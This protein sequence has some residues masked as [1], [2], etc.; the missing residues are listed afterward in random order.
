MNPNLAR[1]NPYPFDRLN[2]LLQTVTPADQ[3]FISLAMGEPQHE[4]P[5]FLIDFLKQGDMAKQSLKTYPPTKGTDELRQAIAGFLRRRFAPAHP[6]PDHQIL[7]VNGTREAL[8]A[9]A[10]A[11]SRPQA[12]PLTLLPNPFYQIYEGAALLAGTTPQ[13][14][15]CP[16]SNDFKPN[17]DDIDADT[18]QRVGMVY[19]CNPGNPH[20]GLMTEQDLQT[21]IRTA[22]E[23][24]VILIADECYSEIYADEAAPPVGL[25]QAAAAMGNTDFKQCLAFNSLSKRSNLPGLRSGYVAG[26]ADLIRQFLLYRT[27]HGSAMPVHAQK[28]STLAWSDERHVIE[29][30]ALYR[31][32]TKAFVQ[33][34]APVWPITPPAASFYLWPETPIDDEQF[35]QNLMQS[36]NIKVLP[37]QY[38]SRTVDGVN[39]GVGRVRIALVAEQS[40][41]IEAAERI[42]VC[43]QDLG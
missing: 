39:P 13:Y 1:L 4:P 9:V 20:G 14:L 36:C 43:F 19:L 37:G 40:D 5:E 15:S 38:L 8:F 6:D 28:L 25:L 18:W 35:T 34:L 30:R 27:Y 17:F 24:D 3:R 2:Q 10:Q 11:L 22:I 32:K 26:N 21:L 16:A 33:T 29:N 7:P 41:C 23:H 12:K 31:T 42:K